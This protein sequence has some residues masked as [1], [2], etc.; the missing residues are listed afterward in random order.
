MGLLLLP[1]LL[2]LTA[3]FLAVIAAEY[4][5]KRPKP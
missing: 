1:P 5:G 3:F 4:V 2:K